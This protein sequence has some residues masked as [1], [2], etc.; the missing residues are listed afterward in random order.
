M[1]SKFLIFIIAFLTMASFLFLK[2]PL[3]FAAS[4]NSISPDVV[5]PGETLVTINGSGFGN[6]FLYKG[7]YFNSVLTYPTS[8]SDSQ[9]IV[10]APASIYSSGN[11]EVSGS[12]DAGKN[13]YSGYC[14]TTTQYQDLF[15]AF[16][17]KPIIT[18]T[19]PQEAQEGELVYIKG[20]YFGSKIGLV[21]FGERKAEI[22][23]WTGELIKVKVPEGAGGAILVQVGNATSDSFNFNILR[24]ISNDTYSGYQTYLNNINIKQTW[25]IQSIGSTNLIVA[26]LD[27]GVYVNHPDLINNMW[28]N[29]GE[30]TGDKKDNDGNGFVDDF[31][32]YNFVNNNADMTTKNEHGTMVAGIIGAQKDNGIGIAGIASGVKIMPVI[33]CNDDGCP[34]QAIIKGIRYAV[35]NGA[36]IINLSLGSTGTVGYST[37]FDAAIKYAYDNDVLIIAAG[38]NGDT[39]GGFGQDLDFIKTSPVCNDGEYNYVLGVG[40]LDKNNKVAYWSSRSSKFIDVYAPGEDIVSTSVAVFTSGNDYANMDGTSFSAPIVSGIAALLKSKYPNLK[41]YEIMDKIISASKDNGGKVE[42]YKILSQTWGDP[43]LTSASKLSVSR[44]EKITL[45]GVRFNADI[46]L[47]LVS[48]KLDFSID[49]KYFVIN[50][51]GNISLNIPSNTEAGD[52]T[53]KLR[54][55]GRDVSFINN[56]RIVSDSNFISDA[57]SNNDS[58]ALVSGQL[59]KNKKYAEVFYVNKD[60]C[61]QWI[62]NEKVATKNFGKLW[63]QKVKNYDEIPQGYKFCDN[64]K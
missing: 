51:A 13:C 30:L 5:I 28:R 48:V 63:W 62:I 16:Y 29:H 18:A 47:R 58:S 40:A 17:V 7:V 44:G 39:E 41:N 22:L 57:Y 27:S 19:V 20:K 35:D 31:Y 60:L 12:F 46:D 52:Y 64:L 50:N 36:K 32:G 4:I 45:L 49:K 53:I 38:G 34:E 23:S 2:T 55:K 3:S 1:N 9:I 21:Y 59:I 43:L 15:Y 56:F 14:Y 25:N 6:S 42:A 24:K 54:Y 10:K 26:V 37:N 11:I 8:W 61:L 33:V